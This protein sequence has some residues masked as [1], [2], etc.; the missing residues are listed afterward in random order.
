MLGCF[1]GLRPLHTRIYTLTDIPCLPPKLQEMER[2]IKARLPL[3][4]EEVTREE[5]RKRI[6]A[7]NEPY[8]LEILDS[9]KVRG[10]GCMWMD[11]RVCVRRCQWYVC[12]WTCR[13]IAPIP[14]IAHTPP[15]PHNQPQTEPITIYHI[16]DEWWDLCAGPHVE[17]TGDLPA[18]AI[19]LESLV[20][21]KETVAGSRGPD[22]SCIR[23]YTRPAGGRVLARGREA[24]HADAHLRDG[25]GEQGA[26]EGVPARDGGGQEA[27]PP[28][29]GQEARPLLHPGGALG[30]VYVGVAA[31]LL[32]LRSYS[33]VFNPNN[34]TNRTRAAGWCSGTPRA[35]PS[36]GSSR[37]SGRYIY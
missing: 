3:R 27:G 13:Q 24:A 11:M 30:S 26:A 28:R 34:K 20:R 15:L 33:Y 36:A 12:T 1:R 29:A 14:F 8:K 32:F 17:G 21:K 37:T 16:G 7:I 22:G 23:I 10:L 5:A 31:V 2:I 4:R 35:P 6:E 18:T 9:I 19:K 25:V